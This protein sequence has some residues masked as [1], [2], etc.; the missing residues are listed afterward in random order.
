[1]RK[2]FIC[3]RWIIIITLLLNTTNV[4]GSNITT[5]RKTIREKGEK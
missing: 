4:L 1:M 3:R 2:Q 5:L